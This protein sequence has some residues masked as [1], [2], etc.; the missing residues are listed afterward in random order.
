MASLGSRGFR[1]LGVWVKGF[2]VDLPKL[3]V[4]VASERTLRRDSGI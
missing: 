4:V 1:R 3:T 2:R